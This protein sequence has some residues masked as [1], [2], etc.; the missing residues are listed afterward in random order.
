MN[1]S[2][3]KNG[4]ARE[5]IES[6]P[7]RQGK[8]GRHCRRFWW[9]WLIAFCLSILVIMIVIVYAI[10]PAV[11]QKELDKT[12]LNLHSFTILEP[13]PTSLL[14]S[15]NS[16]IT[17]A[18]GIAAHSR[19]EPMEVSFFLENHKPIQPFMSLQLPGIKGGSAVPVITTN[20]TTEITSV[21]GL[22]EFSALLL[23]SETLRVAIRGRTTL[24]AGK[25]HTKV[26]YNEVVTI[27][28]FNQLEGMEIEE[29]TLLNQ[30][31]Q[32]D[33]SNLGGKVLIPNP[34]VFEIQMGDVHINMS[35]NGQTLGNGTIPGLHIRPGNNTYDFRAKVQTSA[36]IPL[37]TA[38]GSGNPVVLD[39]RGNGTD[40]NGVS[41]PWLA[42]PLSALNVKV[43]IK[44]R[45]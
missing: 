28:G 33:G 40:I 35:L 29:Y 45:E 41:I 15:V 11:G 23:G 14:L 10:L 7:K 12:V 24:W 5:Y 3:A 21:P 44:A 32:A 37:A 16:T 8:V 17:G 31:Q 1:S 30:T 9:V 20:V 13:S 22:T 27:K 6:T 43:P 36:L 34:T 39:V 18:S 26:N 38:L 2:T 4:E 19:L 42:G 25:L